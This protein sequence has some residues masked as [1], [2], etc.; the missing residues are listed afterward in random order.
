[1]ISSMKTKGIDHIHFTVTDLEKAIEFYQALGLTVAK[2]MDHGGESAQMV[3]DGGGI[4]VD[5]YQARNI[6]NPGYNHYAIKVEDIN[7]ACGELLERG[8]VVDGP[9]YVEATRRKLATI[10]DPNGILVQL[11]EIDDQD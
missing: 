7:A 1:M 10:R 4:V 9:V 5:L 8:F 3:S 2:R 6:D 11:V